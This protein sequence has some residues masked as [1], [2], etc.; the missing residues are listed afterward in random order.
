MD[1]GRILIAPD[2]FKG[3]LTADEAADAI[4][5]G[6]RRVLPEA[7]VDLCP[8]ADG[9]EG[10]V[11][12][13]ARAS[14]VPAA[15]HEL[16]V[17]GPLPEMRVKAQFVTLDA[18]TAV[19]EMAAAS[20][21]ALVPVADRS[22]MGSTTFGTGEL[23]AAAV[24][25]GARKILIGLGGSA[26]MDCGIGCLQALGF[27]VLMKSGETP[28]PT[29]PLCGRDLDDVLTVKHGRGEVTQG[30]ELVALTD[31]ISPLTGPLGAA[32]C[33]G[34]QKGA[35]P[36]EIAAADVAFASLAARTGKGAAAHTQGSGA[37]G[38][39]GFG[40]LAYAGATLSP[41]AP[42]IAEAVGLPARIAAADWC[43]TGE[44]CFDAS[45]L[46]GKVV[47]VVS[48]LCHARRVPCL[49]LTGGRDDQVKV[50]PG[51]VVRSIL[52]PGSAL[53][54]EPVNHAAALTDLAERAFREQ[55]AV[56]RRN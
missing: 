43:L 8:M 46:A 5:A 7:T 19:V 56:T 9:G 50:Q 39:M 36:A 2:K 45:S 28:S 11:A 13:L 27:T 24:K 41:G 23:I 37:A 44:G 48:E 33:F 47:G 35:T 42:Q 17:T 32:R 26:T 55:L 10:T 4:A 15:V 6:V 31:V 29:E 30:I 20:G 16:V 51:L 18:A 25:A 52:P 40:L 34:P 38:G 53:S 21:L 14:T 22:P 1:N 3:T 12:A 49:A 54:V